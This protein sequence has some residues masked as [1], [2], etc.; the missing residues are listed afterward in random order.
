MSRFSVKNF[1]ISAVFVFL[2]SIYYMWDQSPMASSAESDRSPSSAVQLPAP[3]LG[4]VW[5]PDQ[6]KIAN[7][8]AQ[9]SVEIS[10]KNA[11][12]GKFFR[13]AHPK[14]HGCA[15]ATWTT[16]GSELPP[17]TQVGIFATHQEPLSAWV[18]FSNG[19]PAGVTAPDS[20]ADVR[21]FAVK[22]MNVQNTP[23]G[24]HDLVM[25]NSDQFFCRD[26]DQYK[27]MIKSIG[28]GTI[29]A[30]GFFLFHGENRKVLEKARV[31]VESPLALNYGSAVPYKNGN[32]VMRIF[33]RPAAG[34][35]FVKVDSNRP[36]YL[37]EILEQTLAA[38]SFKYDVFVQFNQDLENNPVENPLLAW[39]QQT[40]PLYKAGQ[41]TIMQQENLRR[42]EMNQFC[43]NLSFNPWNSTPEL[44]P[45]GQINRIR[46]ITY[47]TVSKFRHQQN[48]KPQIE[49]VNFDPCSNPSTA[50][51]CR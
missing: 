6:E 36:N 13:D 50:S 15:K 49:P 32:N 37:G 9:S 24:S 3:E 5:G 38:R 28:F 51:L 10:K 46:K 1:F 8:I 40:S 2:G 16:E 48:G 44:R 27:T 45:L 33:V 23:L 43:E 14:H 18:R 35:Q 12:Q 17:E 42:P 19:D 25:M 30:V 31:K 4:E 39:D 41:L 26:A 29:G 47:E 22:L 20:A 7:F 21:G 11:S 34:E